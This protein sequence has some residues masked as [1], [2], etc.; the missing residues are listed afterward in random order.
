MKY[1]YCPQCSAELTAVVIG[2]RERLSCS[3]ECGFVF[4][5]NPTPVVAIIV[6]TPQ[7]I[8]LAH[9]RN[10]PAGIYSV[11]TGFLESKETPE[12]AAAREI[13]E[14]LSLNVVTLSFIGNFILPELNQLII[15][16]HAHAQGEIIL[17]H[18]LDSFKLVAKDDLVGWEETKRFDVARWLK[19][20]RV[21]K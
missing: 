1:R 18:E 16:F 4:W 10:F 21:L 13:K 5:N 7:G 15:A 8:V 17:N 19:E 3:K 9:N 14:E 2:E 20:F 12:I 6:E 11:I